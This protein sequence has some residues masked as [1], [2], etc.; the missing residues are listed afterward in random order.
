MT[1]TELAAHIRQSWPE[2]PVV[3]ATGYAEVPGES[4]LDCRACRSPTASRELAALV[5]H[6]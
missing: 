3:L 6:G 2:L 4:D 5:A 1:G